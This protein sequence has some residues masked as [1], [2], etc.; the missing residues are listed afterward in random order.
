M[1]DMEMHMKMHA[2]ETEIRNIRSAF[3]LLNNVIRAAIIEL[4]EEDNSEAALKL[5]KSL[6]EE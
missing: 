5:L 6:E 3:T 1:N 4:E 2:L